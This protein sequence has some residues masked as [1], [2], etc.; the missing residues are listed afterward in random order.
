MMTGT[1]PWMSLV[2]GTLALLWLGVA[3]TIAILA[4]RRLRLAE[5]VLEAARANATLLELTPARPLLVRPDQKIEADG[6]LL[7]DLGLKSQPKNLSDLAG[8]DSGI[9]P[10][11]LE[12]LRGDID[13]AR[14]SGGRVSR[15]VRAHGS[16]RVF[17]VREPFAITK[18]ARPSGAR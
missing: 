16:P 10:D 15:R 18:P 11:D 5:S 9:S 7:R 3:A 17:D 13:A 12:L 14:M 2:I 1:L 6:Q 4:A 8:N